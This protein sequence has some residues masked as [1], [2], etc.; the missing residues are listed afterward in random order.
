VVNTQSLHT[1]ETPW[2]RQPWSV[3]ITL[4]PLGAVFLAQA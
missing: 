3:M 2:Q 4:P 1:E